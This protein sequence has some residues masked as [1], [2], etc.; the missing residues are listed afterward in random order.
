M[1]EIDRLIRKYMNDDG[2]MKPGSYAEL[3]RYAYAHHHLAL[4]R[5]LRAERAQMEGRHATFC[6]RQVLVT[7][8]Q[9]SGKLRVFLKDVLMHRQEICPFDVLLPEERKG[10]TEVVRA[11][12]AQL[13]AR[14]L[15][16][17]AEVLAMFPGQPPMRYLI[18]QIGP[19]A[20]LFVREQQ[21]APGDVHPVPT[22]AADVVRLTLPFLSGDGH[23]ALVWDDED[24]LLEF[25]RVRRI[26]DMPTFFRGADAGP[27]L[28]AHGGEPLDHLDK[29]FYIVSE[30]REVERARSLAVPMQA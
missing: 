19:G 30:D 18:D 26:S 11:Q 23:P 25:G 6:D 15:W 21:M 5:M 7:G 24:R 8:V 17:N 27:S 10:C 22:T 12:F 3:M 16:K 28:S 13:H 1:T 9:H 4:I 2:T 20:E 29:V 14:K